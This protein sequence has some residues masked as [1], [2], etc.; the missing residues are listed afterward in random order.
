M[1]KW[2]VCEKVFIT[3]MGSCEN[4]L[5]LWKELKRATQQAR[6]AEVIDEYYS[7][8]YIPLLRMS[9]R[10]TDR[11][12]KAQGEGRVTGDMV[13]KHIKNQAEDYTE[14]IVSIFHLTQFINYSPQIC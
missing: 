11:N 14:V 3:K 12:L 8:P 10:N 1:R 2:E 9:D 7:F 13:E 6:Y 4:A 5:L